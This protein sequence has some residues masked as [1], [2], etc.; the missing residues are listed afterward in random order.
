MSANVAER[1]GRFGMHI[2]DAGK[3]G[4]FYSVPEAMDIYQAALGL[5]IDESWLMKIYCSYLPNSHPN[6]TLVSKQ[7]GIDKGKL[8]RIKKSLIN[9]CLIEDNGKHGDGKLNRD[10]NIM[11]FFDALFI[12]I[13]CDANSKIVTSQAMDKVRAAFSRWLGNDESAELYE[14]RGFTFELPLPVNEARKLAEYF[15]VTLNW[16]VIESMQSGAAR[17][18]LENMTVD[19]T[20]ELKLKQAIRD[21]INGA[22]GIQFGYGECYAW[23]RWLSSTSVTVEEV[24]NLTASYVEGHETPNAKE[25]M[26][27]LSNVL[28]SPKNSKI[29]AEREVENALAE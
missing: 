8:S 11:P 1:F 9:K 5:S 27:T 16:Q 12:C 10:I 29:L 22:F 18:K 25:Y 28:Q 21:G 13:L 19:K 17:E 20:R 26:V 23:L 24:E 2:L 4:G 15:G 14:N 3:G 7:T 6:M